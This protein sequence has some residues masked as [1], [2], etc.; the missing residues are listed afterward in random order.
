MDIDIIGFSRGAAQAREFANRIN[1]NT[2]NGAYRYVRDGKQYCQKIN[3]RFMG[4]WDT[5]LSDNWS[6]ASYNFNIVPGF[7]HVAQAVALNEFRYHTLPLGR[8]KPWDTHSWGGFPLESIMGGTVPVGQTRIERGFIGAHADIGGGF[9]P[10][11]NQLA[12]VALVWMVD[13]AEA[14]GVNMLPLPSTISTV[15][16]NPVIHDKSDAIRFGSPKAGSTIV[17]D[18]AWNN[19]YDIPATSIP[20]SGAED[21]EVRYRD[22]SGN[23]TTKTTQRAMT[24]TGMIFAD[25][26][27][28]ITYTPRLDM[29]KSLLGYTTNQTGTVDMQGYL[30]WLNANGYGLTKLTVQ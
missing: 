27:Q 4:L 25:T 14:A 6:G 15:I 21:R 23:I 17:N 12:Q 28:F 29:P 20:G 2:I 26:E 1:A 5:V 30:N 16:A 7:Q 22:D 11:E 10:G 8:A 3:L 13:Q 9:G 18:S 24:G 19:D